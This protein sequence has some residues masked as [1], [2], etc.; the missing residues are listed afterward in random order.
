MLT[1]D[2]VPAQWTRESYGFQVKRMG[3]I[4]FNFFSLDDEMRLDGSSK[5]SFVVTAKNIDVLLDLDPRAPYKEEDAN[6][7]LLLYKNPNQAAVTILKVN[8][9]QDRTFSFSYCEMAENSGEDE[10]VKSFNEITLK[11][12][13]VRMIQVILEFGIPAISGLHALYNP[14]L[15]G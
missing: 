14:A 5:R 8:K 11:P 4:L 6:G 2:V 15:I 9:Q 1:V 10:D 12:G 13:Q 7:D 3:Y